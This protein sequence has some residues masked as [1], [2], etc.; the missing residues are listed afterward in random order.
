MTGT[1]TADQRRL[2]FER[3][4]YRCVTCGTGTGLTYAHRVPVGMGG[5]SLILPPSAGLTQCMPHNQDSDTS[6]GQTLALQMG[7]KLRSSTVNGFHIPFYDFSTGLYWM[8]DD[9]GGR[10]PVADADAK[11]RIWARNFD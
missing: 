10:F 8:P 11:A 3:D 5:S 4:H 2:V 9:V 1:V 6:N 7:W